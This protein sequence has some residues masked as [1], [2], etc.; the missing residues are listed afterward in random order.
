MALNKTA[1]QSALK[2]IF[3]KEGNTSESVA[4]DMAT[5]IEAYVKSGTVTTVVTGTSATGGAV[6][7]SG[8]GSVT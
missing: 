5:A 4:A 1:L 3:E 8:T 6:T 2:T 7:G